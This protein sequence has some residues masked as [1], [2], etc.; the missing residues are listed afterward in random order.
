MTDHRTASLEPW[1]K[2][3]WAI[4]SWTNVYKQS[5]MISNTSFKTKNGWMTVHAEQQSRKTKQEMERHPV[6]RKRQTQK[7]WL[8]KAYTQS[9]LDTVFLPWLQG[10]IIHLV[11]HSFIWNDKQKVD[12]WLFNIYWCYICQISVRKKLSG[13]NV[14]VSLSLCTSLVCSGVLIIVLKCGKPWFPIVVP[15]HIFVCL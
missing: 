13:Q 12:V 8:E 11:T 4:G 5:N 2:R 3:L 15:I 10:N 14:A 1:G 9:S 7:S 6:H